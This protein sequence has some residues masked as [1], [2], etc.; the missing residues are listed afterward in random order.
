MKRLKESGGELI[1]YKVNVTW[2]PE[3]KYVQAEYFSC[4]RDFFLN[5]FIQTKHTF[6]QTVRVG[7]SVVISSLQDVSKRCVCTTSDLL[8]ETLIVRSVTGS[9]RC[10][11]NTVFV[12]IKQ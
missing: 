2:F 6:P 10:I 12:S 4:S 7:G 11:L 1:G 8:S 5:I 9:L 3:K